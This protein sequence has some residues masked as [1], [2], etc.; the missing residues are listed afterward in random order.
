MSTA[1]RPPFVPIRRVITGHSA[2]GKSVIVEDAPVEPHPFGPKQ[3]TFFTDLYWTD[4]FPADNGLEFKDLA[5]DHT[6][7]IFSQNGSSVKLTEFPPGGAS[8]FHRT[9]TLDYAVI[10]HGSITVILD[11]NKRVL[12]NAGDVIVQRGTIH[13]WLN[14]SNEW[15]RMLAIMLPAQKVKVGEKELGPEFRI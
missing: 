13:S 7:D 3:A 5:K 8:P 6:N 2:D 11:D 1:S 9:V 14:E 10:L 15:C 12:L 4:E